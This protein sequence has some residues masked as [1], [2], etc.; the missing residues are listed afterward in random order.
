MK[1]IAILSG[2]GGVGKTTLT[3]ALAVSLKRRGYKTGILDLDLENPSIGVACGINRESLKFQDQL[4]IP[5][6]WEGIPIMSL[7]LLPLGDFIDTPTLIDEERKSELV[8]CLF[9]EVDWGESEIL[10]VDMPP[11]SA[12]EVRALMQLKPYGAFLVTSPQTDSS[13]KNFTVGFSR[14]WPSFIVIS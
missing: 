14:V 1:I 6:T 2:K 9:N 12:E 11:G 5:P 13:T 10:I 7:S 3:L 4:I 8:L